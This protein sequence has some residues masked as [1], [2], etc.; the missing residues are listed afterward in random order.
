MNAQTAF[1]GGLVLGFHG[2][3]PVVEFGGNRITL[4]GAVWKE[5]PMTKLL[6]APE[7]P[8]GG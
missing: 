5:V 1:V 6:T 2:F 7:N 8:L 3:D 4:S